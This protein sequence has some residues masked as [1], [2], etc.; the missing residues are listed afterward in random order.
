VG[1][2]QRSCYVTSATCQ[3]GGTD[4]CRR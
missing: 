3:D 4:S 1:D 2:S